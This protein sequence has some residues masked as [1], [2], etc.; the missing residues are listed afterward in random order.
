M[1]SGGNMT[2]TVG[3][4]RSQL[5]RAELAIALEEAHAAGLPLAVHAH[6]G[7]SRSRRPRRWADSI[8]HCTFF[9]ADGIEADPA[10]LRQLAASRTV[11]SMTAAVVPGATSVYP[12]MSERL[13]AILANHAS[14]Y[15]AGARIVCSSDADVGP[16][17][18][19]TA[20]PLGLTSFLPSIG[21]DQRRSH[22]EPDRLRCRDMRRRRPHRHTGTLQGRAHPGRRRRSAP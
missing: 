16:N 21:H 19:H 17:K 12:A 3:P 2:P 8:E 1:A 18:P 4:H 9:T 14:L 10:L 6:G 22:H 13:A 15:R 11:I 7:Q 20:L 5:G